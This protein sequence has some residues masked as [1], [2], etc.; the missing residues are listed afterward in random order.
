MPNMN[1]DQLVA[2]LLASGLEPDETADITILMDV[3]NSD[4]IQV[5]AHPTD[6]DRRSV[7]ITIVATPIEVENG[8]LLAGFV[9]TIF[10][11]VFD[12]W[13]DLCDKAL[14]VAQQVSA[15]YISTLF[16]SAGFDMQK[17]VETH[18]EEGLEHIHRHLA[19]RLDWA[20]THAFLMRTG[21]RIMDMTGEQRESANLAFEQSWAIVEM[22]GKILSVEDGQ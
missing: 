9:P 3:W 19:R 15:A 22:A 10:G 6:E 20:A 13:H 14:P 11:G 4:V 1:T 12:S 21:E 18:Q 8:R 16:E 17:Y 5:V 2:K 7:T